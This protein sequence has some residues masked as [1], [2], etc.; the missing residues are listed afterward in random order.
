MV[1][2]AYVSFGHQGESRGKIKNL[3]KTYF[4]KER[5]NFICRVF[6]Y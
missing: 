2:T 3:W 5:R 1:S 4:S 6:F